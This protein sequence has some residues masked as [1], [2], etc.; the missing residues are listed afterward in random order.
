MLAYEELHGATGR[1]VRFRAPRHDA[2]KL[3]PQMPP[4]VR[5]NSGLYH[6]RN[7]SVGG[8]AISCGQGTEDIP[9]VGDTAHITLQQ[10]GL[11][12]FE[13]SAR[14]CRREDSV[15][16]SALAFYFLD[17]FVEF[18]KLLS[19]NAQAQ[20]AANSQNIHTADM[21]VRNE[22]RMF[23]ADVL[24]VLRSSKAVFDSTGRT[25]RDA[26]Y[27]FDPMSCYDAS[28]ARLLQQWQG[29]W[30]TGNDLVR[31]IL[32]ERD[33][34]QATKTYTEL[35][36]T[37]EFNRGAIWNRAYSKPLGYPGDFEVMNYVY[38]WQRTGADP[39]AMLIHRLGLECAACVTTRMQMVQDRIAE[40]VAL[41]THRPARILSLGSGPAR[42]VELYLASANPSA[43]SVAFT[44]IDQEEKAL[45]QAQGSI[46][47]HIMRW[48]GHADLQ[49]LNLSFTDMLRQGSDLDKLSPQDLIYSVGLLD[50]LS[51]RRAMAL[52]RRL[53][54]AL[55]PGG[56]LVI[57]NMNDTEMCTIWPMEFVADWTL[58]YR[59]EPQ[60]LSWAQDLQ[61]RMAWT[62]VDPTGRV[63]LLSIRKP[64]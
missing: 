17:S 15:F 4:R 40:T 53:Y 41:K 42:E 25:T 9:K 8:L 61:S 29:L 37:P 55:A 62:E 21:L 36:L 45:L 38:S 63:R 32:G 26:G 43:G 23:C 54:N 5:L 48:K 49:C 3:F 30:R 44:L 18:E 11:P 59:S 19:R 16:G 24:A 2:R 20:I 13:T 34:L 35:V 28:E 33:R 51:D 46:Y 57:G 14:V 56:L 52:T 58:H 60:M 64:A 1:E 31:D 39:Y 6:L 50:Y 7:I 47:P 27:H 12:I 10:S 22:Y